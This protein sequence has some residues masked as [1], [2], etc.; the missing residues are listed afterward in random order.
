MFKSLKPVKKLNPISR[1]L[2]DGTGFNRFL[3][4]HGNIEKQTINN[5]DY[6]HVKFTGKHEQLVLMSLLPGQEIGNEV[7]KH[8]DQFFR[9]EHGTLKFIL[10]NGKDT[11]TLGAG[12]SVVVP[13]GTWHNV[14]NVGRD[15]AKLYTVY[16]QPTHPAGL[17]QKTRPRND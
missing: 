13:L 5:N 8:A 9:I 6:R 1:I 2:S 10:N 12:G 7:H 15:K 17:I 14:V 3:G 4:Y 16:A 11:F